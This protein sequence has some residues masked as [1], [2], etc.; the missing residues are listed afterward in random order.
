M[1]KKCYIPLKGIDDV[2]A[3][4]LNW[5]YTNDSGKRMVAA[6][7]V[8]N[9]RAM[10]EEE[11]GKEL[12]LDNLDKTTEIL[13]KYARKLIILNNE[14]I[15][16]S[17]SNMQKSWKILRRAMPIQERN[18]RISMIASYFS[19]VL[20]EYC[21]NN[22]NV[23]RQAFL[24]G[25]T[26]NGIHYG[27][28]AAIFNGVYNKLLENRARYYAASKSNSYDDYTKE[29]FLKKFEALNRMLV[30]EV[31]IS[32]VAM[33]R[34]TLRDTEG[35]ILGQKY[36]YSAAADLENFRDDELDEAWE[37]SE[38]KREGWMEK[39]DETSAFGSIGLQV[40]RFLSTVPKMILKEVEGVEDILDG[41]REPKAVYERD[42]LGMVR[43]HDA[44]FLH[45]QLVELLRGVQNE[46]DMLNMLMEDGKPKQIWLIPIIDRL[47]NDHLLRTQFFVDFKKGFQ[48]YSMSFIDKD[49]SKKTKSSY[50]KTKI[51]N[52]VTNLLG[53]NYVLRITRGRK[54]SDRSIFSD[55]T[56]ISKGYV[57]WQN[58]AELRD[59]VKEW[60]KETPTTNILASSDAKLLQKG[61]RAPKKSEK[62]QF[63]MDT[64]RAMGIDARLS[65]VEKI[66]SSN[67]I[68]KVREILS[69]YFDAQVGIDPSAKASGISL[70][71]KGNNATLWN[72][73]EYS[74]MSD[75]HMIDFYNEKHKP[76]DEKAKIREHTEKLLDIVTKNQDGLRLEN[77][78]RYMD[79]TMFSDVAPN[80]MSDRLDAIKAY[81]K[82]NNKKGL[83]EYLLS[84]YC[85]TPFMAKK[86]GQLR[87]TIYNYWLDELIKCCETPDNIRL[88]DTF[89]GN[90][91]YIRNL[92]SD[93][94]EFENFTSKTHAIDM[95]N[96]FF[97]D[98][99]QN[100]S[101]ITSTEPD[102]RGRRFKQRMMSAL[103]PV[104]ILGD[105]GV[106]KYLRGPRIRKDGKNKNE[107][108]SESKKEIIEHLFNVYKQELI[109]MNLINKMNEKLK[110]QGYNTVHSTDKFSTLVFLNEDKWKDALGD[111]PQESDVKAVIEQYMNEATQAFIDRLDEF[112]VTERKTDKDGKPLDILANLNQLGTPQTVNEKLEEFFWNTKLATIQQF[113]I[114]TVDPSFYKNTKDLQKRYKEIHAPG[115]AISLLARNPF[116]PGNPYY[117]PVVNGKSDPERAVYIDDLEL[118]FKTEDS[119]FEAAIMANKRTKEFISKYRKAS[120]T[121]GQGWRTL[122]S[123]TSSMS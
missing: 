64:F 53:G 69:D 28:E 18:D 93:V 101:F 91:T 115:S 107:W 51:L 45:S 2:I 12:D 36:E 16:T 117:N 98:E 30:P 110:S 85:D 114:M 38:A 25:F 88:E 29:K 78:A 102:N 31:Y 50:Y 103:Y 62:I 55:S 100:K 80:F 67:D 43:Y 75:I 116:K 7:R 47:K 86:N 87:P 120:L 109:R 4:R 89:A 99:R 52:R 70:V 60:V 58:L 46:D 123:Y 76:E 96:H 82:S 49:M 94:Q 68:Y 104:F 39:T 3:Y 90:F 57:N 79:K 81:V 59:V 56:L 83:K 119:G 65:T 74:K 35:S 111:N 122:S 10:Y 92:G 40:R 106:C 71:I 15:K 41:N 21:K 63:L 105:S 17:V 26:H 33:A 1:S 9:L 95:I 54:L 84:E 108:G 37:A 6:Y 73:G 48:P 23:P 13:R 14:G 72:N 27:G 32:L 118:S 8:A 19:L 22:P 42:D 121:D 66:V 44:A 77:R 97:A 24:E 20:D 11:T 61:P 112:G 34:H 113:Q 5:S